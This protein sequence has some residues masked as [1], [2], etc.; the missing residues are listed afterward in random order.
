MMNYDHSHFLATINTSHSIQS[1]T[2]Y[3]NHHQSSSSSSINC[4]HLPQLH[5]HY[6]INFNQKREQLENVAVA[7]ALQLEAARH[8]TVPIR[9]NFVARGSLNSLSLSDAVLERFYCLYVT[10]RCDLEL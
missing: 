1:L 9:F 7:N 10:L 8:H 2:V 5:H 6:Q 3:I 4:H